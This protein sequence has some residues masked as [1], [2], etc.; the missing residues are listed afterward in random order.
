MRASPASWSWRRYLR[1]SVRGLIVLVLV[2]GVGMGWLVHKARIQREAVGAITT[3]GGN[4]AYDWDWSNGT[5]V[6]GGKPWAPRWLVDRIGID[7]FG[8]VTFVFLNPGD[9]DDATFAHIGRLTQIQLLIHDQSAFDCVVSSS[10]LSDAGL[11]NLAGLTS[12]SHLSLSGTQATDAG[13]VHLEG[14]TKLSHLDLRG[15]RITSTGLAHLKGL[16]S[17]AALTLSGTQV[18]DAGLMH[19][20]GL[21]SLSEL[22]LSHTQ[23]TDAGLVHLAGLTSLSELDLSHTQVTDAGLVQLKRLTNL[24]ELKLHGARIAGTGLAHLR[25][26]KNLSELE[27]DGP[28]LTNVGPPRLTEL[29]A[30]VKALKQASPN[31]R[32][33][34][35]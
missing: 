1:F 20:A 32:I 24:S 8:H 21:T 17:L 10:T 33:F 30:G 25:A 7:Y 4:V 29:D 5:S 28:Q 35:Y 27:L 9:A 26:L 16:T 34:R 18:N 11:S 13:L 6:A 3:A 31:M 22:D 15:P 14:L 12:L 2:N 19:L 23:G